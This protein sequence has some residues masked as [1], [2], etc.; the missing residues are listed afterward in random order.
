VDATDIMADK[1]VNVEADCSDD[2]DDGEGE[3]DV[4]ESGDDT[5]EYDTSD[6]EEGERPPAGSPADNAVFL[7]VPHYY[8]M[9]APYLDADEDEPFSCFDS[10]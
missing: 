2:D 1:Y 4:Y 8:A 6:G 3:D 10:T 5:E 7:K 9:P